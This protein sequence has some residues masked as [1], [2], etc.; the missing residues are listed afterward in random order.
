MI[1]LNYQAFLSL[2]QSDQIETE[3]QE[4]NSVD[5]NNHQQWNHETGWKNALN[6]LRLIV[7]QLFLFWLIYPWLDIFPS[8]N[9]LPRF[10]HL[11]CAMNNL[12]PFMPLDNFTYLLLAYY[13]K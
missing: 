11:I 8:C 9:L 6:N 4:S 5:F 7:Q 2:N 12:N 10:N 13:G 3:V 1:S